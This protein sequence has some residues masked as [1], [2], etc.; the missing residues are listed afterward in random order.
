M[1][2]EGAQGIVVLNKDRGLNS[3]LITYSLWRGE[4]A[5]LSETL[6]PPSEWGVWCHLLE[7]SMGWEEH[8]KFALKNGPSY[9]MT[10][11]ES[12]TGLSSVSGTRFSPG[13]ALSGDN[14]PF[15]SFTEV[16]GGEPCEGRVLRVRFFSH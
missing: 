6:L 9:Y 12:P 1:C 16:S 8:T 15:A 3:S 14:S 13:G 11:A 4:V 10:E 2:L 7:V 5:S